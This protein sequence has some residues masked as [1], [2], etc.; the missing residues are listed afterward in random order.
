[1]LS[2]TLDI[3]EIKK[4]KDNKYVSDFWTKPF[5]LEILKNAFLEV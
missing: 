3:D 5:R 1:V 4:V 2:S